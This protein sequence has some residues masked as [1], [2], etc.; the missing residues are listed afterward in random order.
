[1]PRIKLAIRIDRPPNL[2][3]CGYLYAQGKQ[4]WKKWKM[5]FFA[6]VQVSQYT[7]AMCSY[8]ER[9]SEP[10]EMVQLDGFTV[11]YSES[12][13]G[14][15]GGASFF[16]AMKEGDTIIFS[17]GD[18]EDRTLWVQALYRATGQSYKP[19]PPAQATPKQRHVEPTPVAVP[20]STDDK[21]RRIGLDEYSTADPC[22]FDHPD[23][24]EFL[25]R[26]TLLHR[27]NDQY[28]CLG[29]FSPGQLFVLDE[30]CARYG[31]RLCHRHLWK[32]SELYPK[33][34]NCYRLLCTVYS[35]VFVTVFHRVYSVCSLSRLTELLQIC[36]AHHLFAS[37]ISAETLKAI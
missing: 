1:M 4:A 18:D 28:A 21:S 10:H 34:K 27:L 11:D 23:L 26:M 35:T 19:I 8:Q 3:H 2:K 12:E 16:N 30:Y 7:F 25:Q 15:E 32:V 24:F 13:P 14:L 22:A 6:L 33:L 31:V 37:R 29:W 9:K 36:I 5:R 20:V 17:S